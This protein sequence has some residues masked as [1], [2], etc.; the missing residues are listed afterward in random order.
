MHVPASGL[1]TS[2]QEDENHHTVK[3]NPPE[4]DVTPIAGETIL[5]P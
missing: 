2:A 4:A 5:E 3:R 1:R